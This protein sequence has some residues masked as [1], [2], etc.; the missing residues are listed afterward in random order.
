MLAREH[1]LRGNPF[2]FLGPRPFRAARLRS[3]IVSQHRAGRRLSEILD[4]AYVRRCGSKS[5]CW[6]VLLDVRTI[7]ALEE[8][9]RNAIEESRPGR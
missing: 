8:H 3:Y 4:D 1:T 6:S 2:L 5:F 9:T 7:G